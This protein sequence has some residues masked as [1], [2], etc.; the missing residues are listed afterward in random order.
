MDRKNLSRSYIKQVGVQQV[1]NDAGEQR[2]PAPVRP[3]SAGGVIVGGA[4]AAMSQEYLMFADGT[5]EIP[6]RLRGKVWG[7]ITRMNQLTYIPDYADFE[8][9]QHGVQAIL[10]WMAINDEIALKD[11]DE[12]FYYVSIQLRKSV[13][14]I[15]RK[16]VS[17]VYSE[18]AHQELTSRSILEETR[19]NPA[20]SGLLGRIGSRLKV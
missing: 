18:V 8:R 11:Y 16:L 19:N 13:K 9:L 15:E 1:I 2:P 20:A 5:D 14:G 12:I 10:I 7:I 4:P 3:V 17:P 6:E